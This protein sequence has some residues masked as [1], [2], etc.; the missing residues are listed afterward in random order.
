M[1]TGPQNQGQNLPPLSLAEI[2]GVDIN[3][4]KEVRFELLPLMLAHWQ[5]NSCKLEIVGQK[6]K[7]AITIEAEV[8]LCE[9]VVGD[10]SPD[11]KEKQVGKKHREAFFINKPEDIGRFKAF[12]VDAGVEINGPAKLEDLMASMTGMRFAGKI[13]H[14]TD[15][16]NDPTGETKYAHLS[17]VVSK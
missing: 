10:A 6:N 12:A 16:K 4:V 14:Q 3:E 11:A 9:N 1:A 8:L 17:P 7:P 13:R 5:L 15:L 2:A